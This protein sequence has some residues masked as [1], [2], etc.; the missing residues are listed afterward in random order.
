MS[1]VPILQEY[2]VKNL[3]TDVRT[4]KSESLRAAAN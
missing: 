2:E 1:D 4:G 3:A